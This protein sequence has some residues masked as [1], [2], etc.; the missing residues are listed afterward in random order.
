MTETIRE[1]RESCGFSQRG[2]ADLLGVTDRAVRYWESGDCEIP[3]GRLVPLSR[4][5]GVTTDQLLQSMS[6][7]NILGSDYR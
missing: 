3:T 6:E 4:I 1:L 7:M 5:Y 2:V